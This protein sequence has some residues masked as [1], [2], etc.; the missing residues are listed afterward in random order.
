MQDPFVSQPKISVI[1]TVYNREEYLERCINSLLNQSCTD[2]ELIA[3]DD[4]STD[5]SY[6]ILLDYQRENQNINLIKQKNQKLPLSRNR[7]IGAAL[8]KY[9]T[10]LDSDD[11]Y[12]KDHLAKRIQFM[13]AHPDIDLIHGGFKVI[14]DEY[15]RDKENPDKFIHLSE[16]TVGGTFFGKRN[17]FLELNGFKNI[18][19]SE[20]SDFLERAQKKFKVTKVHFQTYLYHRDS[21]DSITNNYFP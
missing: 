4:G 3:V 15:V 12:G 10:F 20:D 6:K 5:N 17:V 13:K 7:G 11:E 18:E 9:I 1:L 21:P 14:G 19:Y 8:G 16:C 2:W